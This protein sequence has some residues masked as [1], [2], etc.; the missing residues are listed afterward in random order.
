ML[1]RAASS[2]ASSGVDGQLFERLPRLHPPNRRMQIHAR[3]NVIRN[4]RDPLAEFW[5]TIATADID[6]SVLFGQLL[7][8]R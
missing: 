5:A 4:D 3:T 8:A 1:N 7:D 2:D 6:L